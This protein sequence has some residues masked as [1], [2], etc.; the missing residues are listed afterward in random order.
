MTKIIIKDDWI[1]KFKIKVN[2]SVLRM[3]IKLNL[4]H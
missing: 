1:V 2:Q 4:C 3:F